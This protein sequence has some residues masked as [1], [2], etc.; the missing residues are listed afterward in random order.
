M[1]DNICN[2]FKIFQFQAASTHIA[3]VSHK[4]VI[5]GENKKAFLLCQG[6]G[7]TEHTALSSLPR[8]RGDPRS[9]QSLGRQTD[10]HFV[11]SQSKF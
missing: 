10:R 11:D 5:K 7:H 9:A 8:G 3:F 4:I 2:K 6:Q 1:F